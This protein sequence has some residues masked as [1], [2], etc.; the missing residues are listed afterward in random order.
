MSIPPP[1]YAD[2]LLRLAVEAPTA[3]RPTLRL[4]DAG[5]GIGAVLDLT[6]SG[7]TAVAD[8]LRSAAVNAAADN[9]FPAPG[10][11]A[12]V[13]APA[14][15][16]DRGG[17]RADHQPQTHVLGRPV[18][19]VANLGSPPVVTGRSSPAGCARWLDTV[20]ACRG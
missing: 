13:T 20:D 4:R 11:A 10:L 17:G 14:P 18:P 16:S 2:D 6:L 1:E 7:A 12:A 9:D 5:G 3:S 8:M 15:T 19:R